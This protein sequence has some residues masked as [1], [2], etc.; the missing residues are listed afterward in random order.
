MERLRMLLRAKVVLSSELGIDVDAK[1]A[2]LFAVLAYETWNRRP[3]NMPSATGA[4]HP[5]VLGK[6]SLP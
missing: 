6:L 2:I 5:A 3:G 1:E 4:R